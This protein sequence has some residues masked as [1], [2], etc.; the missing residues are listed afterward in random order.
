MK[1]LTYIFFLVSISTASGQQCLIS[2]GGSAA[3]QGGT[4][5]FSIGQID[6]IP[7]SNISNAGV[8]QAYNSPILP[9]TGLTFS[10]TKHEKSVKLKW[11]TISELNSSHFIVQ[12]SIDGIM[13]S[14]EIGTVLSKGN[15]SGINTYDLLDSFPRAG[16]NYYRLK[17]I[18]KDG[19]FNFSKIIAVNFQTTNAISVYPN[20]TKDFLIIDLGNIGLNTQYQLFDLSGRIIKASTLLEKYNII[21]LTYIPQGTYFLK[22]I[23]P[24]NVSSFIVL[25][26]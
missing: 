3:G 16:I 18:D 24:Y 11:E 5:S 6:Y 2:S 8:Q 22:V 1:L 9:V 19:T 26:Q 4:I 10:A 17:Q 21:S 15:N 7:F 14:T 13:F 20:P 25:K 23:D 12:K